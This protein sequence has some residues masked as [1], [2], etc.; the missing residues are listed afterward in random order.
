MTQLWTLLTASLPFISSVV[1]ESVIVPGAAWTDSSGND[2]QAHGA[3][4]LTVSESPKSTISCKLIIY[5]P[6]REH[7]LLVW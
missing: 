5:C 7:F 1:S 6:D 2:I 4:L 3:G